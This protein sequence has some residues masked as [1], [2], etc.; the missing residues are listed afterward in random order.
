ML[1]DGSYKG[2]A[3]ANE[4]KEWLGTL[5]EA[6]KQCLASKQ[7]TVL[8]DFNAD[9]GKWRVC[10]AVKYD[11]KGGA[12]TFKKLKPGEGG[13]CIGLKINKDAGCVKMGKGG[14]VGVYRTGA[15]EVTIDAKKGVNINT[16]SLKIGGK[17]L[18]QIVDA[19]VKAALGGK[20]DDGGD[21]KKDGGGDGKKKQ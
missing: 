6:K 3:K 2:F 20:K 18:Q 10:R 4:N 7:C 5:E 9:D 8:H 11:K 16:N 12:F 21:G 1:P 19:A 15:Q 13:K 17:T 14:D